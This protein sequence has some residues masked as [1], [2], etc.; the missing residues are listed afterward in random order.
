LDTDVVSVD[1]NLEQQ[2]LN[3]GIA[4]IVPA[5]KLLEVINSEKEVA[6]R[7]EAAA[8]FLRQRGPVE[9]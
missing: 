9:D 5:E 8:H 7:K 4:T 1:Q 2:A 3:T 6:R